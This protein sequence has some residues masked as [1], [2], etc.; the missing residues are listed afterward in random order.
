MTKK[1]NATKAL[2]DKGHWEGK[3]ILRNGKIVNA[4]IQ[5]LNV[6]N[7]NYFAMNLKDITEEYTLTKILKEMNNY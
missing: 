4:Y 3:L 2:F 5:I 6:E 1:K 7:K